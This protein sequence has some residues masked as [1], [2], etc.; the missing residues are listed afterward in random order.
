LRPDEALST[1]E[2]CLR[3]HVFVQRHTYHTDNTGARHAH[4]VLSAFAPSASQLADVRG[5]VM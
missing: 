1:F 5:V 3:L 4:C 2:L